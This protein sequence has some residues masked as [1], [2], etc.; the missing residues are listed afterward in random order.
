MTYL[1]V[2]MQVTTTT[3]ANLLAGQPMRDGTVGLPTIATGPSWAAARPVWAARL[4]K[5]SL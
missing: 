4:R 5:G 2:F 3:D 1:N